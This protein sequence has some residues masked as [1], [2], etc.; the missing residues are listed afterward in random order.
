MLPGRD[1]FFPRDSELWRFQASNSEGIK[2]GLCAESW[3]IILVRLRGDHAIKWISMCF[4]QASPARHGIWLRLPP[5]VLVADFVLYT[6]SMMT[7]SGGEF[8]VRWIVEPTQVEL[9]AKNAITAT[10]KTVMRIFT[11]SFMS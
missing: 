2:P 4:L 7:G 3:P 10:A 11:L 1:I 5:L 6:H 9:R 8:S